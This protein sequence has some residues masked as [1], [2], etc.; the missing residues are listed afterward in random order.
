MGVAGILPAV[1]LC[2]WFAGYLIC[3]ASST[4]KSSRG[5]DQRSEKSRS[6]G[7]GWFKRMSIEALED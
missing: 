6:N 7:G 3:I 2:G 1:E 5:Q 4:R